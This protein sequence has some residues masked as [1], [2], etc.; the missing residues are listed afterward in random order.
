MHGHMDVKFLQQVP[1]LFKTCSWATRV[2][3]IAYGLNEY[4]YLT[5]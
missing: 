2:R 4:I 1:V 3:W 5:T